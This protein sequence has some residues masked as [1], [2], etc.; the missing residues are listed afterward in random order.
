MDIKT[1]AYN[2]E[3]EGQNSR[4]KTLRNFSEKYATLVRKHADL[5]TSARKFESLY[6][7]Y[8]DPKENETFMYAVTE[9]ADA[10]AA[11]L[12]AGEQKRET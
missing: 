7:K 10:L 6:R 11:L 12:D 5:V 8:I 3:N 4:A 9:A 2:L 1:I